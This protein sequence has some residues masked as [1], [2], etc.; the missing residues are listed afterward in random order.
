LELDWS[1]KIVESAGWIALDAAVVA[2]GVLALVAFCWQLIEK[3]YVTVVAIFAGGLAGLAPLKPRSSE[4]LA[5]DSRLI[6]LVVK[7]IERRTA[8]VE[9][10]VGLGLVEL[11]VYGDFLDLE[12]ASGSPSGADTRA[13]GLVVEIF[14][15]VDFSL[16]GS[17]FSLAS[18]ALTL[19]TSRIGEVKLF[20]FFETVFGK[21]VARDASIIDSRNLISSAE[22]V[23]GMESLVICPDCTVII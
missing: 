4:F 3:I 23:A 6:G 16:V 17:E 11:R 7:G 5:D 18:V 21:S 19:D 13:R 22:L 14:A 1:E 9:S 15:S 10:Y 12:A 8:F 2:P 20:D